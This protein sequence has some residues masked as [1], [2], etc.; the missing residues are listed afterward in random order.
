MTFQKGDKV[1][2]FDR[3]DP[4]VIVGPFIRREQMLDFDWW[5]RIQLPCGKSVMVP[6]RNKELEK[7]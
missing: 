3:K 4:G 6:Y 7:A 2:V 1:K 5:V